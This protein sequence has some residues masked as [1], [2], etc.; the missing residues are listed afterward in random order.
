MSLDLSD[1]FGR[2]FRRALFTRTTSLAA[3]RLGVVLV[4][5]AYTQWSREVEA[6]Y[7]YL[8]EQ[9]H[10]DGRNFA[11]ARDELCAAGL[12]AVN[13]DGVGRNART[14]WT[15]LFPND[16][17]TA[18]D[19]GNVIDRP[20]TVDG[21]SE[22]SVGTTVEL[23]AGT[24]VESSAGTTAAGRTRSCS[25]PDLDPD[26]QSACG[27][28]TGTRQHLASAQGDALTAAS[29]ED[30]DCAAVFS[31]GVCGR[32]GGSLD[33]DRFCWACIAV[34]PVPTSAALRGRVA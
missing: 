34:T 10:L 9:T 33:E 26:P 8:R 21:E 13:S 32:C 14:G 7:R 19:A 1:G 4:D 22:T 25:D 11:R 31:D 15:L 24:T 28:P 29:E 12:L 6:G 18:D 2:D 17:P 3:T 23:S 27:R 16:R 5:E 20:T 30:A